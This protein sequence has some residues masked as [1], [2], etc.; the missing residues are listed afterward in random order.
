MNSARYTKLETNL[1]HFYWHIPI[2]LLLLCTGAAC[3]GLSELEQP[4]IP[5]TVSQEDSAAVI[6]TLKAMYPDAVEEPDVTST[7]KGGLEELLRSMRYPESARKAY[8]QGRVFVAF[9]VDEEGNVL[10]PMVT[11][12]I[13]GGCDEEVVRV[14]SNTKFN[15][16]RHDG[17]PVKVIMSTS[18]TFKIRDTQVQLLRGYF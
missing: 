7:M 12:G 13:G 17:K 5:N 1:S 18:A 3:A 8:I 4:P 11:K 16:G 6:P 9:V 14:I 15:P 10:S 2:P